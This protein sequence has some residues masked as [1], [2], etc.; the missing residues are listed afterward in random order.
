MD[1]YGHLNQSF[2][3]MHLLGLFKLELLG[4]SKPQVK[5]NLG[6]LALVFTL[7]IIYPRLTINPG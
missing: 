6:Y 1:V 5:G 3:T 2:D 4:H 7:L